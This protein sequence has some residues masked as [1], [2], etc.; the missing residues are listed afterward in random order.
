MLGDN[1]PLRGWKGDLH[2]GG[3]RVPALANW[4]GVLE[5]GV[6]A[7]PVHV[8]DWMP[9][10]CRLAGYG[11]ELPAW[12]GVD[13]WPLVAGG[14]GEA[15]PRILYWK[16]PAG[17]ALREGDMKLIVGSRGSRVELYDLAADPHEKRDLAREQEQTVERLRA[18]LSRVAGADRN[19]E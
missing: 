5:P 2:E 10:L 6:V 15:A 19:R 8:V 1:R 7:G 18:R 4:P 13:I 12:D 16:T 11:R 17:S 3:I 14:A 9:T